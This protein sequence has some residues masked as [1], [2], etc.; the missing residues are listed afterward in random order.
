VCGAGFELEA[1]L[2]V[3]RIGKSELCITGSI[4]TTPKSTFLHCTTVFMPC[5][6]LELRVKDLVGVEGSGFGILR[7]GFWVFFFGFWGL[8]F[9]VLGLGLG[10]R[11]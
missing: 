6:G 5:S 2:R 4:L 11:N 3:R 10:F 1:G 9:G 8:G 7:S